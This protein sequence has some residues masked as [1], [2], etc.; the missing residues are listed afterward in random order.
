MSDGKEFGE[1]IFVIDHVKM[2][3][4]EHDVECHTDTG[5]INGVEISDTQQTCFDEDS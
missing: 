3:N 1:L 5:H 4:Y 2:N